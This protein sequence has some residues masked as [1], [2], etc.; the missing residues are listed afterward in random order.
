MQTGTQGMF[1]HIPR[2]VM[3]FQLR[4]CWRALLYCRDVLGNISCGSTVKFLWKPR[5]V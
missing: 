4:L 1:L 5:L 3:D 2:D